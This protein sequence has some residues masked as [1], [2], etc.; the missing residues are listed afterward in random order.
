MY[1]FHRTLAMTLRLWLYGALAGLAVDHMARGQDR[2]PALEDYN[3]IIWTAKDGAPLEV[4][5]IAQTPDGWLWIGTKNGLYRFDGLHFYPFVAADG[6]RLL[7]TKITKLLAEAD[8][9][10][11]IGYEDGGLS[12]LRADGRLEH[13]AP[14]TKESPVHFAYDMVR[15]IDGSLW[16]TTTSGL[17]HLEHGRWSKVD[18][19]S[20]SGSDM[21]PH[22]ALDSNGQLW[23]AIPGRVFRYDRATRRFFAHL[24]LPE[25]GN[26]SYG[27][28]RSPDGRLWA[29]AGHRYTVV[30]KPASKASTRSGSPVQEAHH[31]ALFDRAGNLWSLRCPTGVCLAAAA[32]SRADDRIDLLAATTSRMDRTWQLSSLAPNVIFEDREGNIWL[33]TAAGIERFRANALR[34]IRLPPTFGTYLCRARR[35]RQGVGRRSPDRARMALRSDPTPSH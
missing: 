31:Y 24:E 5:Q 25:P 18:A 17:L 33:G 3:H 19:A 15:D 8:G 27:F 1:D 28:R 4:N 13:L 22:V 35:R 21:P 2:G 20:A 12:V 6:T 16:V 23:A 14:A 30:S 11:T 29:I 10:L 26:S 7:S 32:G 9:N 34:P